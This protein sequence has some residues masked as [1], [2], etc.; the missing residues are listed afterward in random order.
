MTVLQ[1]HLGLYITLKA[2][3]SSQNPKL[4]A[5][6]HG[7]P[8]SLRMDGSGAGW[9]LQDRLGVLGSVG[10]VH[11]LEMRKGVYGSRV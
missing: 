2:P 4:L 5:L 6:Q 8:I 7:S 10:R 11:G 9:K 3:E 1:L